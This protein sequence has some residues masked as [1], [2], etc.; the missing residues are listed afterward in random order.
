MF[1]LLLL[2]AC[3]TDEQNVWIADFCSTATPETWSGPAETCDLAVRELD[4]ARDNDW[5]RMC[6]YQDQPAICYRESLVGKEYVRV[7]GG[8]EYRVDPYDVP[9]PANLILIKPG[10]KTTWRQAFGPHA[11]SN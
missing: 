10:V 3:F 5:L 2:V 4:R 11:K 1:T 9:A 6:R 8:D 7:I